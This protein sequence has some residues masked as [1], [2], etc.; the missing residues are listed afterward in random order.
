MSKLHLIGHAETTVL[1]NAGVATAQVTGDDIFLIWLAD[2]TQTQTAVNALEADKNGA[3]TAR[4]Q[5]VL[6]G[7]ALAGQFHSP[8]VDPRTPGLIVQPIPGTVD[9]TS[10][11]KASEHGGFATDD[12]HVALLVV[13]GADLSSAHPRAQMINQAV[14]TY[15]V[16]PTILATLGLNPDQLTS[17]RVEHVRVLPGRLR[18]STRPGGAPG[19]RSRRPAAIDPYPTREG[20][21]EHVQ[22]TKA[23]PRRGHPGCR[24]GRPARGSGRCVGRRPRPA[25]PLSIRV[26]ATGTAQRSA[27]DDIVHLGPDI[28]IGWQNGVGSTGARVRPAT[29]TRRWSSTGPTARWSPSGPSSARSTASALTRPATG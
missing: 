3:N 18:S 24:P 23:A 20:E 14:R 7:A 26:F 16:A 22:P 13:N 27:P 15:Q 29:G 10:N 19:P 4:I 1:T 2:Q 5:S 25:A 11:A 12:T 21:R 28:F 8:L 6:S 9:S 17:V